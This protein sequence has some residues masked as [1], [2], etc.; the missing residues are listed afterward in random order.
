MYIRNAV[1]PMDIAQSMVQS[2]SAVLCFAFY[3]VYSTGENKFT[4]CTI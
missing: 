2:M 4:S 3:L 1:S